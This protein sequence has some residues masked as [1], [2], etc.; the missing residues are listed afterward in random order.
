VLT[1]RNGLRAGLL[2]AMKTGMEAI[3]GDVVRH[4]SGE[5]PA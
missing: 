3:M 1:I 4:I 2:P 5:R